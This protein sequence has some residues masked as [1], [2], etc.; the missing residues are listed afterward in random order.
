MPDHLAM[1][2]FKR[3]TGNQ[4]HKRSRLRPENAGPSTG[5]EKPLV[6][7]RMLPSSHFTSGGVGTR[8]PR[9]T[10]TRRSRYGERWL[11]RWPSSAGP[12]AQAS[13]RPGITTA[14]GRPA[15]DGPGAHSSQVEAQPARG[16]GH[17]RRPGRPRPVDSRLRSTPPS[18]QQPAAAGRPRVAATEID[19]W[20]T[21]P[22]SPQ[23]EV[24]SGAQPRV[25]R[26]ALL[27][28]SCLAADFPCRV[29]G[30]HDGG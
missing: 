13:K 20:S 16:R 21:S 5:P 3:R 9:R 30:T 26:D 11:R 15:A 24:D 4:T 25:D 17:P 23:T 14:K 7:A 10:P 22:T 27:L 18:G 19:W 2:C 12:V 6:P 1:A 28:K 29:L 8:M